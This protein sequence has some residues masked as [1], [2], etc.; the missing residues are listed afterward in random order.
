MATKSSALEAL[1]EQVAWLEAV[2]SGYEA[3]S[4]LSVR[5]TKAIEEIGIHVDSRKSR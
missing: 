2:I 1:H 5:V 3:G 4:P